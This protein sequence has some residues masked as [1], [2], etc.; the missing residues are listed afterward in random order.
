LSVLVC[1]K[2]QKVTITK[3][4]GSNKVYEDDTLH[5]THLCKN[6]LIPNIKNLTE[7]HHS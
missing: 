4:R 3:E 6:E 1:V 5:L 2:Y 7:P